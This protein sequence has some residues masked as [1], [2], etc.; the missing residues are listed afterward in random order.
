LRRTYVDPEEEEAHQEEDETE[1]EPEAP[2]EKEEEAEAEEEEEEVEEVEEVE[3]EQ[4]EENA[5]EAAE[6]QSPT[7]EEAK[8]ET[9]TIAPEEPSKIMF[10]YLPTAED[11][12]FLRS[13][14][15]EN[16][17]DISVEYPNKSSLV[18]NALIAALEDENNNVQKACLDF[19]A[20]HFKLASDL[21]TEN[22]K[23]I[24]LEAA[25]NL[26]IRKDQQILRRVY[27]WIFGPADM[28]NKYQITEKNQIVLEY[29]ITAF[30]KIF[31]RVPRDAFQA[32][33]PL[34]VLQNFYMEHDHLVEQTLPFL[35][36][37]FL[38]YVYKYSQAGRDF[39]DE[40]Q[41][42]GARFMEN[43]T[44]YFST[45]LTS[46]SDALD[47]AINEQDNE[48]CL[49]IINLIEFTFRLESAIVNKEENINYLEQKNYLKAIIS[50][51]LRSV[52]S[53]SPDQSNLASFIETALNLNL[54]L[55]DKLEKVERDLID[56]IR[57]K[58]LSEEEINQIMAPGH[59]DYG[60]R[61]TLDRYNVFYE[62]IVDQILAFHRES[63][64]SQKALNLFAAASETIVKIQTFQDDTTLTELPFWV[65]SVLQCVRSSFPAVSIIGIKTMQSLLV[66]SSQKPI[67]EII[68]NLIAKTEESNNRGNDDI[69]RRTTEKLWGLL[70]VHYIQNTVSD[71]LLVFQSHFPQIFSETVSNSFDVPSITGKEAAIRRFGSFWKI[72]SDMA[73][74]DFIESGIGLLEMLEFLDH[75]NP[76][77]RHSSK[78]WLLDAIPY[79]YRIIDPIFEILMQTRKDKE[80][81]HLRLYATDTK[82]YFFTEVY[83]TDIVQDSFRKLRG[84]LITSNE[85]FVRY[86]ISI[87]VSERLRKHHLFFAENDL[88]VQEPCTYLDLLVTL[89]LRYIQ[90]H[91]IEALSPKFQNQNA[92]VNASASE[93]MELLITHI[94]NKEL[95]AQIT[96]FIMEPTLIVLHHAIN[97]NDYV[98][99]VQLLN[100]MKVVLYQSSF[101]NYEPT[102]YKCVALLSSPKFVPNLLRGLHVDQQY[103]R[104]QFINFISMCMSVLT[105]NLHQP[106]V[107]KDNVIL[108]LRAY[109][110]IILSK[111][112]QVAENNDEFEPWES[113]NVSFEDD[114]KNRKID[115]V[116]GDEAKKDEKSKVRGTFTIKSQSQNEIYILL[117]GVKKILDY[118]LKFNTIPEK[119]AGTIFHGA[120]GPG[121]F[122]VVK[123]IFTMGFLQKSAAEDKKDLASIAHADT[124]QAIL[125]DLLRVVYIF[126]YCWRLSKE[127]RVSADFSP[128]GITPYTFEKYNEI[129]KM[130]KENHMKIDPH[131]K[132]VKSLII[133]VLKPLT[134]QYTSNKL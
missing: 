31:S 110:D 95:S 56:L 103:V 18:L 77:L 118:F 79:L 74:S 30:R 32:T 93:F 102:R 68:R 12:A 125:K 92:S 105:E 131:A 124:S 50:G 15:Q 42:A 60:F 57:E 59:F 22:E 63:Q 123:D 64:I 65:H 98:L 130:V 34:K 78:S 53:V 120:E 3:G 134:Y 70:D 84:I 40:V 87:K 112:L 117:E 122:A 97:N 52:S 109:F 16:T 69:I 104:V 47:A 61:E 1:S 81:H 54:N 133:S 113:D 11:E 58:N 26:L 129:N 14:D 132:T 106:D 55:I 83:D 119:E 45:L 13:L 36:I 76:L 35:S 82:Q 127:F 44:S 73:K 37:P 71:L 21:F 19:M 4:A 100:L 29:L 80:G 39:S 2:S 27:T 43:I 114:I 6:Q 91:A 7:K 10:R 108:I 115:M 62:R 33:L 72:A 86:I 8:E 111:N 46:L 17:D 89:C 96:H 116:A 126:I 99:Q 41:K 38:S 94:E 23:Y 5:E 67:Y 28:E 25:L 20:T 121:V 66:S 128:M 90:G 51:I 85:L 24:L 49:E 9:T 88:S 107:L 48:K 101:C 75:D